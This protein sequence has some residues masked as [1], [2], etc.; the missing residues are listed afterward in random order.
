MHLNICSVITELALCLS[1][2]W[3]LSLLVRKEWSRIRPS[4]ALHTIHYSVSGENR[5]INKP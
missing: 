3:V 1:L 4:Q 5:N 2:F